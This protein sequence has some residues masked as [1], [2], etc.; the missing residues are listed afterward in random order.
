MLSANSC[1]VN[2][3][4]YRNF[5]IFNPMIIFIFP[6]NAIITQKKEKGTKNYLGFILLL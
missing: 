2:P 4:A 5:L 1:N 6:P 3:F